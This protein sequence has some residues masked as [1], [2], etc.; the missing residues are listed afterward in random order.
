MRYFCSFVLCCVGIPRHAHQTHEA[1]WDAFTNSINPFTCIS[2][3][4]TASCRENI[5]D[6]ICLQ[7]CR[8]SRLS[9]IAIGCVWLGKCT[10]KD[11]CYYEFLSQCI[12]HHQYHTIFF[13][14]SSLSFFP[15]SLPQQQVLTMSH[16]FLLRVARA[17]AKVHCKLAH[18]TQITPCRCL[19]FWL[20][21]LISQTGTVIF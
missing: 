20:F 9:V 6:V 12:A 7:R 15:W 18:T 19:V 16:N 3:P 1:Y 10:W 4:G 21:K 8:L 17:L 2:Q 11:V 13:A 14:S 5:A